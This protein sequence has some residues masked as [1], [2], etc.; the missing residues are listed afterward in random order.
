MTEAEE[1]RQY[2]E[3]AFICASTSK[4]EYEKQALMELACTWATAAFA[5]QLD[6]DRPSRIRG[7]T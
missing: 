4:D 3:E 5:S 7:E 6:S 1:F 2:A